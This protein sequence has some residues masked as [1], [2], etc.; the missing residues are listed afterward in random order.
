MSRTHLRAFLGAFIALLLLGGIFLVGTA[1]DGDADARGASVAAGAGTE[2]QPEPEP[3]IDTD[4]DADL[5]AV[6]A[7]RV[8]AEAER[9]RALDAYTNILRANEAQQVAAEQDAALRALA[10][11]EREASAGISDS[12]WDRMAQCET[13][14]DWSMVGSR[15]SGGLGFYN[16]TWDSF[17]GREFAAKA[18]QAT[19]EQQ[20]V[21]AN[22][23]ANDVG[24]SGW[25][26][27]SHVG[28]P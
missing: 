18:G 15:Y 27:L 6:D 19:R 8:L 11:A 17:G 12:F 21:V 7:E 5:P 22:R 9:T 24:L 23:V 1:S 25:G 2:A 13:A 14:G 16:G 20:I 28:R 26:C 10:Q 4:G 3:E